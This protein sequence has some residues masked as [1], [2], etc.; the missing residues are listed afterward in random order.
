MELWRKEQMGP[1]V[2]T[3]LSKNA[4]KHAKRVRNDWDDDNN[5]NAAEMESL[6]MENDIA[7][8]HS[9]HND[10]MMNESPNQQLKQNS[11]FSSIHGG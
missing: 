6:M 8:I 11:L 10:K 5:N 3:L 9:I 2:E 1:T 4:A 7:S